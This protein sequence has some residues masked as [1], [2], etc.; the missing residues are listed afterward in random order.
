MA[1]LLKTDFNIRTKIKIFWKGINLFLFWWIFNKTWR[2]SIYFDKKIM[3]WLDYATLTYLFWEIFI[4]NEYKFS[5]HK[6]NPMI[7]DLWANIGVASIYFKRLYPDA[8]I[9]AF[10]P[11]DKH[12]EV[13]KKNIMENKYENVKIE[14]KAVTNYNG[15]IT[16]YT[17]D[18]ASF[19]MSTKKWRI[20]KIETKLQCISINDIIKN[21]QIDLLK[22]DIEWG[23]FDVLKALDDSWKI[24]QIKEM[25]IEYHHNIKD[26]TMSFA[27]FL[28]I[29]EQN[30]FIYWLSTNLFPL[31]AKN[32]FQDIFIHAYKN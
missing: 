27:T 20:S 16:F 10:E 7:L 6:K 21:D 24:N 30:W 2:T 11:D 1:H 17:D 22:M 15:E 8:Q 23:E 3:Y 4:K 14:K 13:L 26:D 18:K 12:F 31:E 9:Q 29:L 32:K 19:I 28:N 25:I 5:T